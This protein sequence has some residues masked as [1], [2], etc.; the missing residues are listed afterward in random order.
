MIATFGKSILLVEDDAILALLEKKQLLEEGYRVNHVTSG[1][2]ALDLVFGKREIFDLILMDIDLGNGI[3]GTETAT[4]ILKQLEVPILFLSSHTEREVVRKTETITSYGYVVKN[5]GF[6]V[7]DASIKM[8]FKLFDA[9]ENI[10]NKKEHLETVLHSIGDAVIATDK[11]GI[12]VKMNP[13]AEY[14]TGWKFDEGQGKK[15]K[16]KKDFGK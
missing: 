3:D 6:T 2:K 9:H 16:D 12:V 8:A 13:V 5:S 11:E 14:L 10:K 7:L 15:L 1:E 4:Q